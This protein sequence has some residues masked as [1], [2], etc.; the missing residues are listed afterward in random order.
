MVGEMVQSSQS[1]YLFTFN[2]LIIIHEFIYSHPA[3]K[4]KFKK[5]VNSHLTTY[6]LFRNVFI[7]IYEV[8]S[9]T[10]NSLFSFTFTHH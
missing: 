6:V 8:Y 5:Y 4:F 2:T 9:F 10:F 1:L 7:H 3:T